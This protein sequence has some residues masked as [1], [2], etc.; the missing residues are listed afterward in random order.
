MKTPGVVSRR[1]RPLKPEHAAW[2][3]ACGTPDMPDLR[4]YDL[5]RSAIR[6]LVHAGVLELTAMKISG[7]KSRETFRRY[8]IEDPSEIAAAIERVGAYVTPRMKHRGRVVPFRK[9]GH[10]TDSRV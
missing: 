4:P 10:N 7:H 2:K 8:A 3:K 9:H 5:R 6:N 1:F